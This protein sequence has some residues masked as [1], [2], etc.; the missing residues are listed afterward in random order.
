VYVN[1]RLITDVI[2]S[3][4]NGNCNELSSR[5]S[6]TWIIGISRLNEKFTKEKRI[7]INENHDNN[8]I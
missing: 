6:E 8:F 5:S 7:K 3:R 1:I 4:S 2:Y